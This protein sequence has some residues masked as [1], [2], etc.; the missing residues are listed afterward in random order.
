FRI[1]GLVE[2]GSLVRG[3][4]ETVTFRVTDGGATVPVAYTGVL[5]DLFGE[6]PGRFLAA[7]QRHQ[8]VLA[9]QVVQ[10]AGGL[11]EEQRQILL[12]P[13]AVMTFSDLLVGQRAS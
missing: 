13:L 6:F 2:E 7:G 4:G 8:P 3:Q 9:R 1:G 10:Q 5:P 12:E 11:V